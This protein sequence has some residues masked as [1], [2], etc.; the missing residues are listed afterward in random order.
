MSRNQVT[1]FDPAKK[2]AGEMISLLDALLVKYADCER[3]YLFWDAGHGM[4]A[5]NCVTEWL[6]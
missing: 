5:T 6:R 2:D 4:T 1:H 3:I